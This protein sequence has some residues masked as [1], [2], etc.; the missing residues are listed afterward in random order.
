VIHLDPI[1]RR[2][3]AR[4]RSMRRGWWSLQVLLLLITLAVLGPA[5]VGNRPLV[6]SHDG[7]LRFPFLADPIPASA[8]GLEGEGEPNWRLVRQRWQA[9]GSE[10]WMVMPVV[11]FSATEVCEVNLLATRGEDGLWRADGNVI[12]EGRIFNL[13]ADGSR[14]R[15]WTVSQG[16]LQGDA[17]LVVG[18]QAIRAK[19][20]DGKLVGQ[21]PAEPAAPAG[22]WEPSGIIFNYVPAPAAP[23]LDGHWLG[24]DESGHDIVARLFGGFRTLLAAACVFLPAM[25]VIGLLL[26]AAMGYFGGW[27]DLIAQRAIEVWSN[28]PYLYAV[29]LLS[30]LLEPSLAALMIILVAFSWIGLA[31]QM[32]AAAFSAASK[33]YVAASRTL[34]AGHLRIIVRHIL[35]NTV[36]V[37][38][39]MLPFSFAGLIASLSA[40]DYLGFGLPPTEPSWGDLLRQ[41]R[42]N[43]T[44]WWIGMPTVGCM[45]GL[46]VLVNFVG[47]AIREAFDARKNDA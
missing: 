6:L 18:G 19:F 17:R 10:S 21:F 34:G 33:D 12:A 26:G 2:R 29:I 30:T 45:V 13:R 7:E 11:P 46:L 42:E 9:E 31:H 27:F 41:G 14:E 16:R 5:L 37:A 15:S 43:W 8:L 40:L 20:I 24:T 36:T 4:F 47:E 25:Y 22:A 44:A 23:G 28:I 39:T 35:P 3:L 1:T 32:R 38:V